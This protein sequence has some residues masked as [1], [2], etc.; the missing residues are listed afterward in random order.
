MRVGP[1]VVALVLFSATIAQRH[2]TSTEFRIDPAAYGPLL[3]TIAKGESRGNYNA[4]FGNAANKRIR[5]TEMPV[6]EVLQWQKDF[7]RK[8]SV[9][10]AVGKYQFIR[11]T[12]QGLVQ[13]LSLDPR[14]E[15][16]EKLQDKLAIKLLERRGAHAFVQKKLTREQF[17]TN[18]AKEWAALPKV[19][20]S[21]PGE[22]Y[23][24]GDGINKAHIS[25]DEVFKA[26]TTLQTQAAI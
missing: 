15:F 20:G 21:N 23:Y 4:H 19:K 14:V 8:G 6:G 2:F 13:Q 16:D 22:S 1:L 18:L 12:L 24:A 10:S 25:I 7:V 9:S 17:A 3:N 26:L 5:F 11:P